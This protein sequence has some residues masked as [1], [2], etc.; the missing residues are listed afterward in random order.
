VGRRSAVVQLEGR[1]GD[2]I[3]LRVEEEHE[4]EAETVKENGETREKREKK[5]E[6]KGEGSNR[7]DCRWLT[8]GW[9][10]R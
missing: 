7:A 9:D 6:K 8:S 3:V 4:M 10:E 5:E 1:E 2:G